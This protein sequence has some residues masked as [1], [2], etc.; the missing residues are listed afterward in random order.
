MSCLNEKIDLAPFLSFCSSLEKGACRDYFLSVNS[1]EKHSLQFQL[2]GWILGIF[3]FWESWEENSS[4]CLSLVILTGGR[5]AKI[6]WFLS[7]TNSWI[8]RLF[9]MRL[10]PRITTRLEVLFFSKRFKSSSSFFLPMNFLCFALSLGDAFTM[11]FLWYEISFQLYTTGMT[12]VNLMMQNLD[13]FLPHRNDI[14][15]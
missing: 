1:N 12:N 7:F 6:Q 10:R 9:P 8:R 4:I 11:S 5:P 13:L 14:F 15:L 2:L 3:K